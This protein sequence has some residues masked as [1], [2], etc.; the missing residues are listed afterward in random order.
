[1]FLGLSFEMVLASLG[2][3]LL[4]LAFFLQLFIP[5][6]KD[7]YLVLLLNLMGGAIAGGASYLMKIWP[8]VILE[9]VWT[10]VALIAF[11]KL[12]VQGKTNSR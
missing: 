8:F 4:L 9:I 12:V 10:L 3:T 2:V 6:Y 1:M 5:R 7:G 11:I